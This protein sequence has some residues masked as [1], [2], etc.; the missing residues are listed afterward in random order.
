LDSGRAK[1]AIHGRGR[2]MV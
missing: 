1:E 2:D